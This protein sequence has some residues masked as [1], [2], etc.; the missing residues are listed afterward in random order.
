MRNQV[1]ANLDSR[2]S[3][4]TKAWGKSPAFVYC[5]WK[6]S[7]RDAKPLGKMRHRLFLRDD[8]FSH[9]WSTPLLA[10]NGILGFSIS[11]DKMSKH[12][13]TAKR[14]TPMEMRRCTSAVS[15]QLSFI[16]MCALIPGLKHLANQYQLRLL[17]SRGLLGFRLV[18]SLSWALLPAASILF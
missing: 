15:S 8:Y 3:S 7:W 9:H 6:F 18:S 5:P 10:S 12:A 4:S 14:S 16:P 2:E 13:V 1:A 17:L 11:R